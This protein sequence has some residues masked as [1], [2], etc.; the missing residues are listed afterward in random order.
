[1][2]TGHFLLVG[3][4]GLQ[5]TGG[6]SSFVTIGLEKQIAVK[7]NVVQKSIFKVWVTADFPVFSLPPHSK[8]LSF[9]TKSMNTRVGHSENSSTDTINTYL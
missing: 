8:L 6:V 1:M 9:T 2:K 7:V 4:G 3:C 5:R